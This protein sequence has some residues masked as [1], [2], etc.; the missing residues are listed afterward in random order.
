MRKATLFFLTIGVASAGV[1]T[2]GT[3]DCLTTGCY[4]LNDPTSG[5][6]LQGLAPNAST[7]AT[8]AFGH[9]YPF[10]PTL[11]DFPGTDQIYVGSVQTASDDG[12]SNYSGRLNGP[13]VLTMDYS[14]LVGAGQTVQTLTLGLAL[15]DF[16]FPAFGNPFTFMVNGVADP[17]LTTLA[18][19]LNETGPIVQFVTIGISPSILASDNVLTVSIDE[20][21]DGGDGYAID[22]ATV[23]VTTVT[24][25]VP[26][27]GSFVLLAGWIAMFALAGGRLKKPQA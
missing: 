25:A 20:G 17:A 15:D 22:F 10:A 12:Y 18:E 4:G 26:E 13:D 23:G 14:S 2:F 21:G 5:A 24:S 9:G 6:Q 3:E 11:G 16:Q 19:S 1:L 7:I 27:P 8:S